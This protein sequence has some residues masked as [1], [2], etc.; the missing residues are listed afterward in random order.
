VLRKTVVL[1]HR[2]DNRDHA[3]HQ[4][5]KT[6]FVVGWVYTKH[7]FYAVVY[8]VSL[9]A[10]QSRSFYSPL[11]SHLAQSVSAGEVSSEH[12]R[13]CVVD[14]LLSPHTYLLPKLFYY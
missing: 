7:L 2:V 9:H 10:V 11:R 13:E 4:R 6:H 8:G 12:G 1:R 14:F 3:T 5:R